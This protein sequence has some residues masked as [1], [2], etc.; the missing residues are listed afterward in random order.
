MSAG[1][2]TVK[3]GAPAHAAA[4]F[5]TAVLTKTQAAGQTQLRVLWSWYAAGAWSVPDNPRLA[6]ARQPR[7]Y[8]LHVVRETAGESLDEDPCVD[9][10][11]QLLTAFQRQVAAV[12]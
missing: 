11:R 9:L 1:R 10:V 12:E 2:S 4:E 3:D 6:F 5:K 8:K 7:L